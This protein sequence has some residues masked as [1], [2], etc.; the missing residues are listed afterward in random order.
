MVEI[1]L[2]QPASDVVYEIL[3]H[4]YDFSPSTL[5]KKLFPRLRKT[6]LSPTELWRE[7]LR[8]KLLKSPR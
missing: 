3:Y 4:L 5:K 6:P 8:E 1:A 2:Q 7:K